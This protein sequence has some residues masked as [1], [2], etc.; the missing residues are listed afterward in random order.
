MSLEYDITSAGENIYV[1]SNSDEYGVIYPHL[2]ITLKESGDLQITNISNGL[3]TEVLDCRSGETI[4][5]NGEH[6]FIDSDNEEHKITTLFNDF[7]YEYLRLEVEDDDFSENVFEVSLPCVI[8][9]G[10]YPIRKV[11][12]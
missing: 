12:M 9:I 3:I 6:K 4:R 5:I 7:K 10:Y 11:G 8:T 2:S 1:H